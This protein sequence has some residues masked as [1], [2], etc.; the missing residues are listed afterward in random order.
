[1]VKIRT[2]EELRA[3]ARS[4]G[5][6][7]AVTGDVSRLVERGSVQHRVGADAMRELGI[8]EEQIVAKYGYSPEPFTERQQEPRR[9]TAAG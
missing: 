7:S 2:R 8:A 4:R 5:M 1:M 3:C 6:V 9:M